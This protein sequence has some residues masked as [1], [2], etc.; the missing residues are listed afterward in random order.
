MNIFKDVHLASK[1]I[2]QDFEDGS[3]TPKWLAYPIMYVIL[4]CITLVNIIKGADSDRRD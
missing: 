2:A 3:A 1:D 4:F